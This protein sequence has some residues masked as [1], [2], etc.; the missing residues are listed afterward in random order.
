MLLAGV[1][2]ILISTFLTYVSIENIQKI[3]ANLDLRL[4]NL[5]SRSI[6]QTFQVDRL[7]GLV[8]G[9]AM[10][11]MA[12]LIFL[13]ILGFMTNRILCIVGLLFRPR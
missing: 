3:L 1:Y 7:A 5:E 10:T 12:I 13:L 9:V 8:V 2:F 4:Q 6:A 11:C